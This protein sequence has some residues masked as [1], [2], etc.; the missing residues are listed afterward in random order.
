MKQKLLALALISALT[1]LSLNNSYAQSVKS[2]TFGFDVEVA[3]DPKAQA[4]EQAQLSKRV[5]ELLKGA[6]R[7]IEQRR[8]SNERTRQEALLHIAT[9]KLHGKTPVYGQEKEDLE[10][11]VANA[12]AKL[13]ELN[14]QEQANLAQVGNELNNLAEN[15]KVSTG[16]KEQK[17][18]GF[19]NYEQ[20]PQ[21]LAQNSQEKEPSQTELQVNKLMD[22][23]EDQ[24]FF[25]RNSQVPIIEEEEE[26]AFTALDSAKQ[27]LDPEMYL[28][29]E[30]GILLPNQP[31]N[32]DPKTR[33]QVRSY[34]EQSLKARNLRLKGYERD[35]LN[36]LLFN[37]GV[38]V[39]DTGHV[40]TLETYLPYEQTE[41][42]LAPGIPMPKDS[43]Q[44]VRASN[45]A[46]LSPIYQQANTATTTPADVL[47]QEPISSSQ[48]NLNLKPATNT[49]SSLPTPTPTPTLAPG[50]PLRTTPSS[51]QGVLLPEEEFM[52]K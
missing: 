5:N 27:L 42:M 3:Q 20:A 7:S 13:A 6:D 30:Q 47:P 9:Q 33:E 8:L 50:I 43:R 38:Q 11:I 44:I 39:L 10:K 37:Y 36:A 32:L 1:S 15:K 48:V 51:T 2:P 17:R 46:N 52:P 14:K 29:S 40:I 41:P 45:N 19:F 26:E 24:G 35:L 23:I 4:Q 31:L 34:I 21:D 49:S 18:S 22:A 16:Q 12:K 28:N 25:K